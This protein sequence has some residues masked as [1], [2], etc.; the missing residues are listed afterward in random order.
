LSTLGIFA[1]ETSRSK[2]T[3]LNGKTRLWMPLRKPLWTL[4]YAVRSTRPCNSEH[5]E[6]CKARSIDTSHATKG[7]VHW[8]TGV[9][10]R[11]SET[12]YCSSYDMDCFE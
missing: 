4:Q 10:L 3:C 12:Q 2:R 9:L 1:T 5:V 7:G 6:L 11:L 8:L